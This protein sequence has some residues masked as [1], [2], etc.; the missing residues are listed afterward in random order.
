VLVA[1]IPADEDRRLSLLEAC[2]IMAAQGGLPYLV[3]EYLDGYDLGQVVDEQGRVPYAQAFAWCADAC[4]GVRAAHDLGVVHRDLKPSNIFLAA[5]AGEHP[6]VKVIDFGIAREEASQRI[7]SAEDLLGSPAYMSPEQMTTVSDID[8]RSDVWS[9]GACLY[10]L[11]TGKIPFD[12]DTAFQMFAAVTA[13]PPV[14][15]RAYVPDAPAAVQAIISTC[16][17]KNREDRYGS[18][19]E[20]AAA[21]RAV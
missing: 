7:T 3:L 17:E 10:E 16:L 12:G 9:M 6:I 18:M 15:L 2:H 19:R 14:P 4:E 13:R 11:V 20:L 21:L 5:R 1:P 8:A